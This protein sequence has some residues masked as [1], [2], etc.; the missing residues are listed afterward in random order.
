MI[1]QIAGRL[2]ETVGA[3]LPAGRRASDPFSFDSDPR[4]SETAWYVDP[5]VTVSTGMIGGVESVTASFVVWVSRPAADDAAGAAVSL[6]GDLSRLRHALAALDVDRDGRVVV[7]G[8]I[9]TDVRPRGEGAVTVVGAVRVQFEYEA[10]AE[11]P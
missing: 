6:A 8:R 2:V 7:G 4:D 1:E 10:T 9:A 11:D 3:T 5:P